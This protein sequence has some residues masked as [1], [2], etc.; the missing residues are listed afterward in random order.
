MESFESCATCGGDGQIGNAF[1]SSMRC[2]SCHGTGRRFEDTGLRDVTKTK[3]S[4]YQSTNRAP[5]VEKKVWP[6]GFEAVR[7][8]TD[9]KDSRTVS[10]ETKT[11]LIR[12][13]IEYETV[14]GTCTQT[15]IKK[16][17]KQLK[18]PAP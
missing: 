18:P 1:G 6:S 2:P 5:V 14:H 12:E 7:L 16:V 4:H 15:F 13:I 11:K 10:E 8:A 3:P 9:V 17:R